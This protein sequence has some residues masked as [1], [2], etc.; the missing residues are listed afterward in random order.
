MP[1]THDVSRS[2]IR[3]ARPDNDLVTLMDG[4][5][6]VNDALTPG[7][8]TFGSAVKPGVGHIYGKWSVII[9]S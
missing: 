2:R 5:K 4:K 7:A 9:C 6:A 8:G 3:S 1:V